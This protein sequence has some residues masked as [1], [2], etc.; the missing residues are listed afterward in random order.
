MQVKPWADFLTDWRSATTDQWR[1]WKR[2]AALLLRQFTSAQLRVEWLLQEDNCAWRKSSYRNTRNFICKP[3][4]SLQIGWD[5]KTG[6]VQVGRQGVSLPEGHC[7]HDN[8]T[9]SFI[10][11][12]LFML[13]TQ[14]PAWWSKHIGPLALEINLTVDF[15]PQTPVGPCGAAPLWG[16]EECS[17]CPS[18][19]QTM[20]EELV[21]NCE[22]TALLTDSQ[23]WI[24]TLPQPL[25][26]LLCCSPGSRPELGC[27]WMSRVPV[28]DCKVGWGDSRTQVSS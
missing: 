6:K 17:S 15:S 23:A 12:I 26:T 20:K 24:E 7:T 13:S 21:I 28:R 14:S 27:L 19:L 16:L 18:S 11:F 2:K 8:P 25:L 9:C 5:M 4:S 22:T 3:P 1:E 10:H